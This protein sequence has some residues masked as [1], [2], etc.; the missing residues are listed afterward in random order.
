MFELDDPAQAALLKL[1]VNAI[2]GAMI[3]AFAEALALGAAG[4]LETARVVEV[5][6]ASSFHSPLFLMKGELIEK[7]D[8]E[9]RFAM[10][11]AEKDQR[12]VQEAAGDLGARVP[13]NEV[14]RRLFATACETG[15]SGKDYSAVGEMFLEWAGRK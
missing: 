10:P 13:L 11:L 6:Q 14:V 4:G 8:F 3:N 15:R 2:G 9:P 7:R 12:L 5:L 1:C